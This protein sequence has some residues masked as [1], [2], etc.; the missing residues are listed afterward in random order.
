ME[1]KRAERE[2]GVAESRHIREEEK[3]T[4]AESNEGVK[5]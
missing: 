2:H 4:G 5:S 1:R 3:H